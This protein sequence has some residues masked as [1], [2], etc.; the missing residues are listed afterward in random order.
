MVTHPGGDG[1]ASLG[2]ACDASTGS[3]VLVQAIQNDVAL[4]NVRLDRTL[5]RETGPNHAKNTREYTHITHELSLAR[6]VS[7]GMTL[8]SCA[9]VLGNTLGSRAAIRQLGADIRGV[10]QWHH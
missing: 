9:H 7:D 6:R 10:L 8:V 2:F 3:P 5:E 1:V 4:A